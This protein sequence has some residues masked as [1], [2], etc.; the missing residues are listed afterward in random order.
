MQDLI[1]SV[2][3]SLAFKP[4]GEETVGIGGFVEKIGSSIRK[5]R[6]GLFNKPPV[7]A[8]PP[9][10]KAETPPSRNYMKEEY[11][12]PMMED[13]ALPPMEETM[14]EEAPLKKMKEEMIPLARVA[15]EKEA[16]GTSGAVKRKESSIRWRKGE[17]IGCG[18]FGRVYMGMNLDSGELLAVKEVAIG[19]NSAS[20]KAQDQLLELE[21]EVNLLKNLSHP[22]IV[23]YLGTAREED[24]LHIL[25]EFVPGGSI[26]SL[27]G[28]FGSFP[29][30]VIRMYTKQLL[31]GLEYLHKYKIMHRDIKGANI[32]VDNKGC[33]K[34]AD[35]G[36]SK[37]VEALATVTG[38]KSMKGTPYW[39][40]PEVIVQSGHS[41]SADIWSV[42][43]T[44]IE[45]ATGKAPWSQQYQEVAALF[46]IGTTKSHPPIPEHL[47][48]EA[49]DFLLKCLQKEPDL[50]PTASDLLKHPFVTGERQESRLLCR[51][52]PLGSSGMRMAALGVDLEKSMNVETKMTYNSLKDVNV[53]DG[54]T[55][56]TMY[57]N[58]LSDSQSF[59][60]PVN[61]DDDMCL[62]DDSD[63]LVFGTPAKSTSTLLSRDYNQSFNP[64]CE[65][66]DHWQCKFDESPEL[67][68]S[69]NEL[70]SSQIIKTGNR[71]HV[72][73]DVDCGFTFPRG[74]A[75]EDEDEATES[76]IREFLDEKALELK[77]LQTPLY[78]EFYNSLNVA[79][80]VSPVGEENVSSNNNLPPKSRSPSRMVSRRFSTALD[81]E[82]SPSPS[83]CSRRV[84][85]IGDINYQASPDKE[86]D[87]QRD[88]L[89]PHASFFEREKKWKEELV[90]ELE[91]KRELMRQ[92]GAA[93][94][95][96]PKDR[97]VIRN[98]D[99]LRFASP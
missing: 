87:S 3:R 91:R 40:A 81:V 64:M 73:G 69:G 23:R 61:S 97:I 57:P 48:A 93:K 20:K 88:P 37:K 9:I 83:S 32:L 8:L 60:Q 1:G 59:W 42:G 71:S 72:S 38:A 82:N 19:A 92:A 84:S 54:V 18:A 68:R 15:K 10:P 34:L 52:S 21:K 26:S 47:S 4:S 90:E 30:S 22:N 94:T 49:Q 95:S 55:C 33:I 85:N 89:T 28:K 79:G 58:Q 12:I 98:K 63:D 31:L 44:V 5:S 65:P 99:R 25:L 45:M 67:K 76:K 2:R 77:K 39:M 27:L 51:P 74:P 6:I 96:S 66:S 56:S 70:L 50:R 53:A 29:E 35:F 78:E 86:L 43:C 17:M 16:V 7:H 13:E 36:A 46:Y 14:E 24:S 41:Y 75:S 11:P 80:P 62:I